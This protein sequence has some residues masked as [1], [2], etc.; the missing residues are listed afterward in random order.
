MKINVKRQNKETLSYSRRP[1][2]PRPART[3]VF[4]GHFHIA[5]VILGIIQRIIRRIT[6]R[7]SIT[8]RVSKLFIS[9]LSRALLL[10]EFAGEAWHGRRT[11][12]P[13]ILVLVTGPARTRCH[14]I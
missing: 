11:G 12:S 6:R 9:S 1:E 5:G 3:S 7:I 4:R 2:T 14:S 10:L 8:C 13:L